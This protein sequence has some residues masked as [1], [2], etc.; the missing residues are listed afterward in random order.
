MSDT[1]FDNPRRFP[2]LDVAGVAGSLLFAVDIR[3]ANMSLNGL[4]VETECKLLIGQR[5][6]IVLRSEGSDVQLAGTVVWCELTKTARASDEVRAVYRVGIEFDQVLSEEGESLR[7]L[8]DGHLIVPVE[9]RIFGRFE[10]DQA[11]SVRSQF[12]LRVL[13]LSLS[14]MLMETEYTPSLGERLPL[15]LKLA[16][17]TLELMGRVAHIEP[18]HADLTRIGVEFVDLSEAGRHMLSRFIQTEVSEDEEP[19][20]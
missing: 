8:L 2:R 16:E 15:Q 13:R 4:Q 3:V 1:D 12:E 10:L 19:A 18:A 6:T 17:K 14:G 9:R 7:Q 5:Y 20:S 11:A